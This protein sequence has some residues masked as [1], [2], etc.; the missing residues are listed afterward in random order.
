MLL[1]RDAAPTNLLDFATPKFCASGDDHL[2]IIGKIK[3]K[4]PFDRD[5]CDINKRELLAATHVRS[6]G[7]EQLPT[8]GYSVRGIPPLSTGDSTTGSEAAVMSSLDKS[9]VASSADG[10]AAADAVAA[11]ECSSDIVV[12]SRV[13]ERSGIRNKYSEGHTCGNLIMRI[14]NHVCASHNV[15]V[16]QPLPRLMTFAAL[17]NTPS[18]R[19]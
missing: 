4:P 10:R 2:R 1:R 8:V 11:M 9:C 15:T 19:R 7:V 16:V 12:D 17:Q 5:Y 6:V 13:T 3:V 14:T 18:M